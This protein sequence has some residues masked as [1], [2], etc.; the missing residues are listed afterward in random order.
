MPDR[1]HTNRVFQRAKTAFNLVQLLVVGYRVA[2]RQIVLADMDTVAATLERD[3]PDANL[4]QGVLVTPMRTELVADV[5][6]TVLL[7]FA[8][9]VAF[10]VSQGQ[11]RCSP[12]TGTYCTA[13]GRLPVSFPARL[14]RKTSDVLEEKAPPSWLWKGRSVHL[15]GGKAYETVQVKGQDERREFLILWGLKPLGGRPSS[16]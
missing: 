6:Q 2:R 5:R 10:L 14:V 4:N 3:Y 16:G 13:R 1:S 15:V 7:L 9:V 11:P 8:A 12:D